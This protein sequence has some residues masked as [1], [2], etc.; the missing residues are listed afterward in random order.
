MKSEKSEQPTTKAVDVLVPIVESVLTFRADERITLST[1]ARL[2][3]RAV[4]MLRI[5]D[6]SERSAL[7]NAVVFAVAK[8]RG[9]VLM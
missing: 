3:N 2:S 5:T 7:E 9:L 8:Q 4:S 6:A 1:L